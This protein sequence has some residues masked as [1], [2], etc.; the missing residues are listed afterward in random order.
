MEK[1]LQWDTAIFR[2][3]NST[4]SNSFSDW[5][6]P[7]LRNPL[8]WYP[9]YLFLLLFAAINYK[10]NGWWW[11]AFCAITVI[12]ANYISSGIMKPTFNRLRP[13]NVPEYSSWINILVHR[14]QNGSFTS[15]HAANHFGF[16]MYFYMT[17]KQNFAK[18]KPALFFV[19][20]IAICYAQVY[21][22]IHYPLDI[23]GGAIIGIVIGY[24]WAT[25]FNRKFTLL[26]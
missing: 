6:T 12:M 9:L 24:L 10:K 15:S 20:A 21:I 11:V 16:A 13:C 5:I 23:I 26:A 7:F 1:I 2:L 8:T 17:L 4:G 14:P 18:W 25:V 19:W 3:I 22:G